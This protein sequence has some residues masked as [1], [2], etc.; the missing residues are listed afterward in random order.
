MPSKLQAKSFA[1]EINHQLSDELPSLRN[2]TLLFKEKELYSV[3]LRDLHTPNTWEK[4]N[5]SNLALKGTVGFKPKCRVV[6]IN[7]FRLNNQCLITNSYNCSLA[8]DPV[9]AMDGDYFYDL[10]GYIF[11][12]AWHRRYSNKCWMKESL[13]EYILFPN[14]H[15]Y[16]ENIKD[17]IK[18]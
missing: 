4:K 3:L 15:I 5:D 12:S 7:G 2:Y 6:E 1:H 10:S 14:D 11:C 18:H 13:I 8:C 9:M 16:F 17:Q